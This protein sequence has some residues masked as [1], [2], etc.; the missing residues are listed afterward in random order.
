[1]TTRSSVEYAVK[2]LNECLEADPEAFNALH[3]ARVI[4]ND[5]LADHPSV[6]VG[7]IDHDSFY[8]GPVLNAEE[9]AEEQ[10]ELMHLRMLGLINGLFGTDEDGIGFILCNIE[11]NGNII[12]FVVRNPDALEDA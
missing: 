5:K 9:G 8:R 3:F 1:M 6:Q 10:P 12:N 4:V 11:D 2:V 7:S